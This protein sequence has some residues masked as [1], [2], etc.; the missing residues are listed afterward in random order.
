MIYLKKVRLINWYGFCNVTM[1]VGF[2]TLIAGRNGNGKSVILDAVK[3]AAYGDTV[4]NKSTENKGTRTLSSYTRGL[5]DATARTYMR[6]AEKIPNIYSHI[7]LEYYDADNRKSFLLGTILET[8]AS[9]NVVPFRYVMDQTEMD[10]IQHLYEDEGGRKPYSSSQFQKKYGVLLLNREQGISKFM[11][12]TGLKLNMEQTRIYLRKL[13]G[14]MTYDPDAKIDQFIR[15]SVLEDKKVDFSKLIE[16]KANIDQLNGTFDSIQKEIGELEEIIREYDGYE[17]EKLRLLIDDIKVVYK[18]MG[19]RRSSIEK[20]TRERELATKEQE[21]AEERISDNEYREQEKSQKL[22]EVLASLDQMDCMRLI[23]SE[24]EHLER[25]EREKG[26]LDKERKRLEIFQQ[27]V[28]ELI[29]VLIELQ[30]KIENPEIL[31]SLEESRYSPAEKQTAA[32]EFKRVL[33]HTRDR[34]VVDM[35]RLED[36]IAGVEGQMLDQMAILE[37]CKKNRNDFSQVPESVNLKQEINREF[38]KRRI[39]SEAKFACEYVIGLK[40]EEWRNSI[41][42]FLGNRRFSILVEPEY[43]DIADEIFNRSVY[44]YGH[45]FNTRLLM[46]REVKADPESAVRFLDIRNPVAQKYFEYQLGRMKAVPLDEIK[47]HENAISKEGR[48]SVSMDGYYLRFER[49]RSYAL[50]RETMELN[51]IRAERQYEQLHTE[52]REMLEEKKTLAALKGQLDAGRESFK[53][54][55]YDANEQY[56][57]IM[58]QIREAR[59]NL[60]KLH[61]AQANDREFMELNLLREQLESSL[62]ELQGARRELFGVKS[63]CQAKIENTVQRLEDETEGLKREEEAFKE[64]ELTEYGAVQKAVKE[65]D[66]YL[67]N[68][69]KG[70]GGLIA[71][72]SKRKARSEI[73][74]HSRA[75]LTMSGEYNGRRPEES[76]LPAGLDCRAAYEKRKSKIWMD[77]LQEIKQKLDAQTRRYEDIFKNEFV[78][79]I[80][81]SCNRSMEDLKLM[82]G[83]LAKLKFTTRYQFDVHYNKD[84][85][86]YAKIIEYARYL[87][88]REQF[89]GSGGQM[90]LGVFSSYSQEEADQLE[91]DIQGIINRMILKN[92]SDAIERFADYRNYMTYEILLTNDTLKNAKLSRQTGYNSGAEVQIPYLLI[93]SSALLL[94]YN[95]KLNS[96]RLMFIDEPFAKMDPANVK[97]MLEFLKSQRL[98]VVFCAPDKTESIGNECEVIL[99]VLR[100]KPDFMQLGV[101]Q[102]HE[103]KENGL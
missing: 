47:N 71:P 101:V 99:P 7:V 10:Q 58:G 70:P 98:Q 57:N 62:K 68:G 26:E 67:E 35:A 4:F 44:R 69:G 52:K 34:L 28:S 38:V 46:K 82:N 53:E 14:V 20:L 61:Q 24:E 29:H 102:F 66:R 39:S 41:E 90:I 22:R 5:L 95:Q 9:N 42:A 54:Y 84:M 3:Y 89:G 94:I 33:E 103:D 63:R 88:E 2:F 59:K 96:T 11:Q 80:F 12:M 87:D 92:N 50:G 77:D 56:Q 91:Q 30:C 36:R 25:L 48:V 72:D 15:E 23:R 37:E 21:Q 1:P 83:E 86:D 49:I 32:K 6:P 79:T 16:A 51:R 19:E 97:R 27:R 76:R 93:L 81:R 60:E 73:E 43:Y 78:L 85:S 17:G 31:A 65:Y 74:R 75:I 64:Y 40:D 13:R 8:G 100:V 55:I 18:N 45:L